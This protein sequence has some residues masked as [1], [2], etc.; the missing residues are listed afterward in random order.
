VARAVEVG[1]LDQ[2]PR[3]RT[4]DEFADLGQAIRGMTA[5]LQELADYAQE[6]ATGHL[7]ARVTPRSDR[8]VL[9]MALHDM[10]GNLRE[11]VDRASEVESLRRLDESRRELLN[12]VSHNLRTLLGIIKGAVS[13]ILEADRDL[14]QDQLNEYLEMADSECDFLDTLVTA[15]L[16]T[17]SLGHESFPPRREPTDLVR[18][19]ETVVRR[20]SS[21]FTSH[22]IRFV[23]PAGSAQ[24]FVDPE[25]VRQVLLNLL[26][27]ATRYS[28]PDTEVEVSL[29]IRADTVTFAV[30]DRGPGID[31]AYQARARSISGSDRD[32][33]RGRADRHRRR[34]AQELN[35]PPRSQSR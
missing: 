27:N 15:L 12:N 35:L 25:G 18:L 5:Y 21:L 29:D 30:A 10:A 28:P 31:P 7:D 33:R 9:G 26:E 24:V 20:A 6:V 23:E 22:K 13:S 4:G 14:D 1:D 8:D 16:Q 11:L 2:I 17:A 3:I 32:H 19:A 34:P